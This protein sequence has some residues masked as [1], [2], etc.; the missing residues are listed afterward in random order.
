MTREA[1]LGEYQ[2]RISEFS[3]EDPKLVAD[4]RTTLARLELVSH[5]SAV[6]HGRTHGGEEPSRAPTGG[7]V[8]HPGKMEPDEK[9]AFPESIYVRTLDHYRW[10]VAHCKDLD[11][12]EAIRVEADETLG[13]WRR[14]EL[15][16]EP[17]LSSPQWKRWAAES[18]LSVE[19]IARRSSVS[20]K[21]VYEIRAKYGKE[22]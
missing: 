12:L 19:E 22:A 2:R 14:Q 13:K 17:A 3:R 21:Y 16:A 5:T 9:E 8:E 7:D 11:E 20:R 1:M 6:N 15:P 18:T 10:R 4:L